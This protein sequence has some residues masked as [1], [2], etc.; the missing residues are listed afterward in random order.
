M[1]VPIS[2]FANVED[3]EH[4]RVQPA[5]K[6]AASKAAPVCGRIIYFPGRRLKFTKG[7]REKLGGKVCIT[8]KEAEAYFSE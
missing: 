3:R 1:F 4:H 6:L 7:F 2:R 8:G 5:R